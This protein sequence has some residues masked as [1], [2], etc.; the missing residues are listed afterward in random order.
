VFTTNDTTRQWFISQLYDASSISALD[1]A[2]AESTPGPLL[3]VIVCNREIWLFS[4]TGISVWANAGTSPFPFQR[5]PGATMEKGCGAALSPAELD[6]TLFWLGAD[7]I[8]YSASGYSPQRISNHGIEETL[9]YAATNSTVSDAYGMTYTMG[10]HHFYALTLP[11]F[12]RTLV[13]DVTAQSWH[14]RQSGTSIAPQGWHVKWIC[15]A[16]GKIY[17]GL[18]NGQLCTLDLD[19]YQDAGSAI[20]RVMV[21][22]PLYGDGKRASVSVLE[23]ECELGVGISTGQGSVPTVTM[24]MSTDGG[25]TWGN[26]RTAP[27]NPM[28]SRKA[29]AIFRRLGIFRQAAFEFSLSD[30]VKATSFGMRYEPVP[31]TA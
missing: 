3:R 27:L 15:T 25:M 30:P 12:D 18:D 29:R 9:R 26:E 20:R 8:V 22:N 14:E 10:G 5:I 28:G 6:N 1:F 11:T 21:S 19:T 24:R 16:F 13:Y 31:A 4:S 17:A 7:L 2:T 23:M